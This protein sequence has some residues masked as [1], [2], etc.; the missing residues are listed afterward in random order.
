MT[1]ETQ[2]KEVW[3]HPATRKEVTFVDETV[4]NRFFEN[5]DP[6]EWTQRE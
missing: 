5:R 4:K 2:F 3:F 6:S 1:N